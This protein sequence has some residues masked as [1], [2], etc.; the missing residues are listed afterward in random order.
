M[1]DV[2]IFHPGAPSNQD[3]TMEAQYQANENA[4]KRSYELRVRETEKATFTPLIYSTHGGMSP[5]TTAFHKRLASLI[6]NKTQERYADVVNVMR[7]KICF[8][9]LSTV[10]ISLRGER[11]KKKHTR[12]TPL[13]CVSFNMVP[14]MNSYECY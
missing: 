10:L 3:K 13:S 11:G 1:F 9:M 8:S 2:R 4:K 7:T 5:Q 12:E 14:E 6:A